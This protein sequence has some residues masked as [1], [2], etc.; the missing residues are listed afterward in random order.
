MELTMRVV[1][2]MLHLY[3]MAH[4]NKLNK[5]RRRVRHNANYVD[6]AQIHGYMSGPST[7]ICLHYKSYRAEPRRSGPSP[8]PLGGPGPHDIW[9][10][11]AR[12][13]AFT[14]HQTGLGTVPSPVKLCSVNGA[15]VLY[16]YGSHTIAELGNRYRVRP[17]DYCGWATVFVYQSWIY[18][19]LWGCHGTL[20][21]FR[22]GCIA[23]IRPYIGSELGLSFPGWTWVGV[24]WMRDGRFVWL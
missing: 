21:A 2:I 13:V 23:V 11:R 9:V 22:L 8:P 18:R 7:V 17:R 5:S 12:S 24:F 1:Y 15:Y 4:L 20:H 6:L 3:Y 14:L 19:P 10:G 16:L